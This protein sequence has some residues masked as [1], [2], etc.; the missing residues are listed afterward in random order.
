MQS[1]FR[2]DSE[3]LTEPRWEPNSLTPKFC[4]LFI[5]FLE[6]ELLAGD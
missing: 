2:K 5:S 3:E 1:N 6:A 4:Y